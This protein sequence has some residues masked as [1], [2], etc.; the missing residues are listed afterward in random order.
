MNAI[1]V[2]YLLAIGILLIGLE[3]LTFSF[4]LFFLGLGFILIAI[5]SSLIVFDNGYVQI[6]LAFSIA[7]MTAIALR[8]NLLERLSKTSQEKE[9]RAHISGIG[10]VE[11][12]TVK[13]DGTYWKTLND[14]S[15]YENGE[16]V[17]VIDVKDNM[18]VLK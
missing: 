5:V 16:K 11:D 1:E 2:S 3:V 12:D 15:S 18:V 10:Y 17:E 8:K 4:V 6:A 7:L 13:F 9:E 14:L